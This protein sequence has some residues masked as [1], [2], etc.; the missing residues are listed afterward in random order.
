MDYLRELFGLSGQTA[1][2]VGGTGVLCGRMC[3]ALAAAGAEVVVAGRSA[4]RGNERVAA[5][6]RAGGEAQ[7]LPVD[8]LS[9][10]SIE[11]LAATVQE[12][13]GAIDILI[14]GAGLNSAVPYFAIDDASWDQVVDTNLK[15]VHQ[16]CQI[17]A[18]PMT[19]RG[20]GSIINVASIASIVPLSRVFAYAASK[21]AVVNYTQNL[22]RELAPKG[23][24]VNAI[25]PGFIPAEQNRQILDADRVAKILGRTPM[26]RFGTPE[27]LDGAILLLASNRA[28]AFITGVNLIVDGGFAAT[29]I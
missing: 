28:G 5:I 6:R 24:R 29:A 16:A 7:F 8:I 12:Q 21:A 19:E 23:V 4:E 13:R 10:A 9:R 20:R 3:H 1:V 15:S 27:E 11:Q 22:A 26:A 2:V 25:S 14:N 17:F 18:R